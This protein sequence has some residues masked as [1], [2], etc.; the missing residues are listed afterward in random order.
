MITKEKIRI[1]NRYNGDIDDWARQGSRKEHASISDQEWYLI[2]ELIQGLHLI[3]NGLASSV[4]L[5]NIDLKLK[6]HC[7]EDTIIL[8]KKMVL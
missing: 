7:D 1:Y 3:K 5:E 2:D 6:A 8:L 4:F